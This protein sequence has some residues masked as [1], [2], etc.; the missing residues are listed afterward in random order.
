MLFCNKL[1]DGVYWVRC[2]TFLRRT[3]SRIDLLP[4]ISSTCFE[5]VSLLACA[6]P[7]KISCTASDSALH[8][9]MYSG[10]HNALFGGL[11]PGNV[12][13]SLEKISEIYGW[14]LRVKIFKID[15]F[16]F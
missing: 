5:R 12:Q 14:P 11:Q 1:W 8:V 3:S 9:Y 7:L 4:T 15:F 16:E 2:T 10:R 6:D 13:C